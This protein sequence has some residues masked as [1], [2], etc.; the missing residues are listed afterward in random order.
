VAG[1]PLP[2]LVWQFYE[3]G[4]TM[5]LGSDET[6][7]WRSTTEEVYDQFWMQTVRYLTE[8]RLSGGKRQLL[9]TDSEAYELGDV[10][11]VSAMQLDENFAPIEAESLRLSVAAPDGQGKDLLE[12]PLEPDPTAKGWY[13]GVFVPGTLGEYHLQLEGGAEKR[14]RVERPELEF[15]EPQLDEA[16]LRG[17]A[18]GTGGGYHWLWEAAVIADLVP[19]RR[20]TVVTTDEPIPLWDNWLS[21]AVLAGLLT[22]EWIG[23]KW[24]RLL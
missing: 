3:G 23:R 2:V 5:F 15:R 6:W 13:R 8:G 19:D 7:R 1:E 11:R 18:E 17:L 14:L 20:R 21:L 12:V 24:N 9:Q 16:A 10:V 22:I 4:R